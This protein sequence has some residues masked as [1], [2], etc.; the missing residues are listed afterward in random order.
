MK[1]GERILLVDDDPTF[2][3]VAGQ[4]SVKRVTG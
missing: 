4:F 2:L 1:D 3:Q